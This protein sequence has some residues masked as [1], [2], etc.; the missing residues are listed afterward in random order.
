MTHRRTTIRA[1]V[2][3]LLAGASTAAGSRVYDT[4]LFPANEQPSI[5]VTTPSDS[6]TDFIDVTSVGDFLNEVTVQVECYGQSNA[7]LG[8][9]LD[10]LCEDVEAAIFGDP[11]L[12]GEGVTFRIH[13]VGLESTT[14]DYSLEVDP[15]AGRATMNFT[16]AYEQSTT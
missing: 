15:Q 12:A 10:D 14:L 6:R 16:Y 1:A 3:S 2:V 5:I 7:T 11:Y 9:S 8:A 13:R 4:R